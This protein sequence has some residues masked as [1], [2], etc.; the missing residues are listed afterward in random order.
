MSLHKFKSKVN[1]IV[2]EFVEK[3]N[4]YFCAGLKFF[5]DQDGN[6]LVVHI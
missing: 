1:G 3:S 2:V 6:N 4:L 5:K